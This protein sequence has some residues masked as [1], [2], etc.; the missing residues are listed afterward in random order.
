MSVYSVC[1]SET[2]FLCAQ[3][4]KGSPA[5]DFLVCQDA[6]SGSPDSVAQKCATEASLDWQKISTCY[7]GDQG[8]TLKQ[9]EI[10]YF[11]KRFPKA[12][13]I[14]RIEIN[15]DSQSSSSFTYAALLK[16]LCATG[17]QAGACSTDA[18]VV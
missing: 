8:K 10:Q 18:I 4:V 17:I 13:H 16:V 9:T 6:A 15:G 7:S 3:A 14:P 1:P 2:Y 5:V 11:E 12:I